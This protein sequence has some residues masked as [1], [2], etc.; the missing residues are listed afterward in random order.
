MRKGSSP[1]V[2]ALT[3]AIGSGKSTALAAFGKAGATTISTDAIAHELIAPGGAAVAAVKR[4]FGVTDRAA[5]AKAV[6]A[7]PA[8]RRAL[9]KLLHPRIMAEVKRQ[10]ARAKGVVV[11][12][13]PLLF[14]AGLEKRFDLSVAVDAPEA[15]RLKRSR[16]GA[17][18]ARRRGKAQLSG[19]EKARRADVVL[20]NS[21][22][23]KR[24]E[25]GVKD[26]YR[27]F[28]LIAGVRG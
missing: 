21:D 14:E 20:D 6:F 25:T 15:A 10:S 16:L 18:E 11:V 23:K 26:L 8:K 24:L 28:A 3:G 9:E 1:L 27:A 22:G 12:E 2:V 13:V 7:S 17:A 5:L 4:A 19:A